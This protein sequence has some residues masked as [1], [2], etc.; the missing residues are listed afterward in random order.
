M[1]KMIRYE[2][3][4]MDHPKLYCKYLKLEIPRDKWF[5]NPSI[6]NSTTCTQCNYSC[7]II[8]NKEKEMI[9]RGYGVEVTTKCGNKL[10]IRSDKPIQ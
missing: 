7:E 4:P 6:D 8:T 1:Q 9:E 5:C 3:I 2:Y 10:V